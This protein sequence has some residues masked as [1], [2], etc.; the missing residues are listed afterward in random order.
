MKLL[1]FPVILFC[2]CLIT[3]IALNQWLDLVI[4][5]I[6]YAFLGLLVVFIPL[7]YIGRHQ[8]HKTIWFGLTTLLLMITAGALIHASHK[9]VHRDSHYTNYIK[10]DTFSRFILEIS[11]VLKPN[12]FNDRYYANVISYNNQPVNGKLLLNIS[13]DSLAKAL[14]VGEIIAVT[15]KPLNLPTVKNPH[16]FDYKA[17]LERQYVYLQINTDVSQILQTDQYVK[18][19]SYYA[20]K[21]RNHIIKQLEF[22][23]LK[24]D[25]MA[26]VKA[27][28]LGQRQDLSEEIQNNFA[29]AGAI[30]ILAISGLHIGIILLILNWLL[31]PFEYIKNGSYIKTAI[32]V[33]LLWSYAIVAGL[34]PSVVRAVT[35]FTA[36]A[37]AINLK[38][39]NNIYNTLAVSA[40]LLLLFKPNFL[41]EVGFQ[42]SYTAV[43]GIVS[44]QPIL[45]KLWS[46]R[47]WLPRKIWE[48]FTVTIA[49]QASVLPISIYYFHQFPSL[50]FISN[51]VII[52]FLGV[53]L[54]FGFFIM[55]F[56]SLGWMHG[57][58]VALYTKIITWLNLFIEW[59]ASF[60]RL[61]IKD[62]PL[63]VLEL[64]AL[65]FLIATAVGFIEKR[66]GQR[67]VWVLVSIMT[68]QLAHLATLKNT[69]T[70]ELVV[71]HKTAE[72]II[73]MKT[74]RHL[75]LFTS[76]NSLDINQNLIRNY[77][78]GNRIKR[79]ETVLLDN[80]ITWENKLILV[81]DSTGIYDINFKPDMV[82]LQNSPKI[83]LTRLINKLNPPQIIAD[84]SNYVSYIEH[85]RATCTEKEIPFH[86][87][88]QMGFY[89]IKK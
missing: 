59:I 13:R 25:E 77:S 29:N 43:I 19:T 39:A 62:I 72:S 7:Y 49:A 33:L 89:I 58:I 35:M 74:G 75:Q 20:A 86:S 68:F 31:K 12:R 57:W 9:P 70:T 4:D 15:A 65:F 71:F 61:L 64:V 52:P 28:L 80:V 47:Y 60:E 88:R 26:V 5:Y 85:W 63:S 51:L 17:Y 37:I 11:D 40:F 38:R 53:I 21:F 73:G 2:L 56:A 79:I 32:L 84:G 18:S 36:V 78:V 46:I 66:T 22:Y 55:I 67:L 3:G 54:G 87:T 81:I 23:G 10:T 6:I 45:F 24:G 30:H 1:K 27:M 41:F 83:N 42:M 82:I 48:I 14:H 69:E 44:I 8:V 50:F 16:Q 34:S 76:S